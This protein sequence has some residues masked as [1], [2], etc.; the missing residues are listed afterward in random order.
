MSIRGGIHLGG[1]N[2]Q[3]AIVGDDHGVLGSAPQPDAGGRADV[4]AEIGS[5]TSA[6]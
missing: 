6:G 4:A 1:T 3:A 5:G 2:S